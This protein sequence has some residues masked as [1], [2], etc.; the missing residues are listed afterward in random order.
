MKEVLLPIFVLV[1]LATI[2]L[3]LP[4]ALLDYLLACNIILALL[5]LVSSLYVSNPLKLSALPSMLLLATLFR[6]ALNISTT[7]LILS[8]QSPGEVVTAFGS[9]V[10]QGNLVVGLV[11]FLVITLVQLI[12]I[13]KGSERVAEVAARFTLDALPGKQ[14]SIDADIR[15]GLITAE[16]AKN[17]RQELQL[18]SKFYGAL[19]GSMK[20]IK[21]DAIAGIVITAINLIF[22]ILLG[23]SMQELTI[24]ESINRYSLYTIGDGLISQIP[25]LLNSLSAGII[26][27]YVG[28]ANGDISLSNS[29]LGQLG[30]NKIVKL[31]IAGLSL[32][33]AVTPGLPFLPFASIALFLMINLAINKNSQLKNQPNFEQIRFEPKGEALVT[34]ELSQTM[35]K[36]FENAESFTHFVESLRQTIYNQSGLVLLPPEITK[37]LDE[38]AIYTIKIR[39]LTICTVKNSQ[40]NQDLKDK[41]KNDFI[42]AI[43]SN[44]LFLL[45]DLMTKRLVDNYE[46]NGSELLTNLIPETITITKTTEVL[47]SL[48]AENISIK[49]FDQIMQALSE[50]S[51]NASST[52]EL[53][54]LVRVHLKRNICNDYQMYTE[55][56]GIYALSKLL[57][58]QLFKAEKYGEKIDDLLITDLI[59]ISQN[60][61]HNSII[62]C[63][64]GSRALLRDCLSEVNKNFKFMAW[65]EL[66]KNAKWE[67]VDTLQSERMINMKDEELQMR[68]VA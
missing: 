18:E 66:D 23:I 3:P 54:E 48:L 58:L 29:M 39:G 43:I 46:E 32:I 36:E 68:L 17:K 27:T 16:E 14:M 55:T 9:V 12:V 53:T 52:R 26:V 44:S 34:L 35:L 25:A 45:D 63:S 31:L 4:P 11:V 62:V 49:P 19:D 15:A 60:L 64:R 5:L 38:N 37:T 56:K 59:Q 21:G 42:N 10:I 13:S 20:F 50:H 47:R 57:D 51:K 24:A 67:I 7:R 65:D 40:S 22:G 61:P 6:L 33:L 41:L 1:V 8:G 30:Q 2:M 28:Q